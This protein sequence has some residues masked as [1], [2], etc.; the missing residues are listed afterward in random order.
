MSAKKRQR[1]FTL[2][3]MMVVVGIVIMVLAAGI[4]TIRNTAKGAR[5]ASSFQ[6]VRQEMQI[7][8][9]AAIQ[10]RTT[11]RVTFTPAFGSTPAQIRSERM[12]TDG[13]A[14]FSPGSTRV[15]SLPKDY[16]FVV[17]PGI[18]N[19]VASTPDNQGMGVY[20]I[21]LDYANGAAGTRTIRF[22]SDGSARNETGKYSGGVVYFAKR[23]DLWTSHA[24]TVLG[25]TGRIGAWKLKSN[26][27]SSTQW[28]PE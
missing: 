19:T 22:Y 5:A 9:Q 25:Y 12:R 21:D 24:L 15:L 10:Q 18:P 6:S 4:P 7:A 2:F 8:R 14:D 13:A 11:Y 26:G 23:G 1:G 17:V 16:D 20:A 27:A 28:R 3:E